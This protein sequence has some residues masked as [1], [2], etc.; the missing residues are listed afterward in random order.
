MDAACA[1]VLGVEAAAPLD[2]EVRLQKRPGSSNLITSA[3]VPPAI[4]RP[5]FTKALSP[6]IINTSVQLHR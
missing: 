2:R 6:K 1:A 3:P 5:L 4:W